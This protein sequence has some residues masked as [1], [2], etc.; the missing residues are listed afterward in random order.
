MTAFIAQHTPEMRARARALWVAGWSAL[1]IEGEL[2]VSDTTIRK[3]SSQEGWGGRKIVPRSDDW[4]PEQIAKLRALWDEGLSSSEIGRRMG[5]SKN[6]ILGKAH[7]L[8]LPPRKQA[9]GWPEERTAQLRA[10]WGE[11]L[12]APEIARRLGVSVHAVINKV[13][14]LPDLPRRG[15]WLPAL[16]SVDPE[17]AKKRAPRIA[18][19]RAPK[20]AATRPAAPRLVSA[21]APVPKPAVAAPQRPRLGAPLTGLVRTCQFIE[22][23][24]PDWQF[25]QDPAEIGRSYCAHHSAVCYWR[26]DAA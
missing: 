17:P 16:A 21:P 24:K 11:C 18:A 7:R 13:A 19:R 3:W 25:C 12:S 5:V 8:S 14:R 1:R 20:P 26:R 15:S 23:D 22:G 2:G 4:S 10:L 9:E 6:A